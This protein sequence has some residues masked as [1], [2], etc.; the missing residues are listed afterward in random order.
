MLYSSFRSTEGSIDTI[1]Q[2]ILGSSATEKTIKVK[3]FQ[4]FREREVIHTINYSFLIPI[5][6]YIYNNYY[7]TSDNILIIDFPGRKLQVFW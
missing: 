2:A 1:K 3:S 7:F 6:I 5:Y 4:L